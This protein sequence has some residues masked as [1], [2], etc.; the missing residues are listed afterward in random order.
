MNV[1]FYL[2]ETEETYLELPKS[3]A[4]YWAWQSAAVGLFPYWGRYHWVLQTYLYLK[5][6]GLPDAPELIWG[7]RSR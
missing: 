7:W 1:S 3:V 5:D 6:A 2:P 4:E